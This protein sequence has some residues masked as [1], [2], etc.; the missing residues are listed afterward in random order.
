MA[1]A[2]KRAPKARQDGL[3]AGGFAAAVEAALGPLADPANAG[4][5]AAYMKHRFKFLGIKTPARRAATRAL[6]RAQQAEVVRSAGVLWSKP[7]REYQY[8]ACDL[9]ERHADTLTASAFP[10]V[11]RLA[12][13]K[14]RW[15]T[16]DALSKVVGVLVR[17]HP[18]LASKVE[19]LAS[20]KDLW[21]RRVA[22]LHQLGF[23]E[24]TD[25][26]RL[27]RVCLANA[28]DPEFFISK[29]IGWALREH[30]H[31]DPRA[32]RRFLD[33]HPATFSALTVREAR[34]H[35]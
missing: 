32:I 31:H 4:P 28:V 13:L 17:R 33:D 5:M 20:D 22:I 24:E 9:L 6:I 30:A 25:V 35:L 7:Y 27:F 12:T 3:T 15:D 34:K 1:P 2:R 11:L 8:V 16:V 18:Q 21:L 19:R 10:S 23:K 26:G 14:S 29:A